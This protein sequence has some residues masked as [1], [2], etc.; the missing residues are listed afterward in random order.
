[1]R[2]IY[3]IA[4]FFY[5]DRSYK[6]EDVQML[7]RMVLF[8][9]ALLSL[10]VMACPAQARAQSSALRALFVACEDFLSQPSMSPSS[11]NNVA[12]V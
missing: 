5:F 3:K 11:S 2:L 6:G 1:M 8:A 10:L 7:R 9:A 4:Y 12:I